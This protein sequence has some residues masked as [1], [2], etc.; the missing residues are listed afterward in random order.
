MPAD[1]VE[2]V[3]EH[4]G[5]DWLIHG[6][7]VTARGSTLAALDR[8]LASSLG[9]GNDLPAEP[10]TVHMRFNQQCL[11]DWIR[12]YMPHYFNRTVRIRPVAMPFDHEPG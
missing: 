6:H 4:D 7:G 3:L 8:A 2:L 5:R 10:L 11:P 9:A 1:E 12:Q